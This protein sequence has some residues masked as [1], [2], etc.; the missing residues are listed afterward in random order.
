MKTA[1]SKPKTIISKKLSNYLKNKILTNF[2]KDPTFILAISGGPDSVA[3]LH[4]LQEIN[5][6]TILTHVN[7]NLRG[8][9]SK[10]DQELVE[11]YAKKFQ[12][13][14]FIHNVQAKKLSGNLENNC[15]NIRYKFFEQIQTKIQKQFKSTNKPIIIIAHN[16]DDKIETFLLNITRGSRLSGLKS[17]QEIDYTRNIF[18]PL[19][20]ISKIELLDYLKENKIK[21]RLDKSNKDTKFIRNFIRHKIIPEFQ[22]INPTFTKTLNSTIQNLTI[23]IDA[24]NNI[25]QKWL[26]IN[27]QQN[28]FS[29]NLFLQQEKAIQYQI[30][31][32]LYFQFNQ[33]NLTTPRLIEII[34]LLQKRKSNLKKEFGPKNLLKINKGKNQKEYI[35]YIS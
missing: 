32:I 30:I 14:L 17:I 12:L 29:L 22:K 11:Y 1:I 26:K 35:V 9:D 28:Q 7:Y 16:L 15:R 6:Q 23:N 13:Q 25:S 20:E 3:L 8:K 34:N 2:K 24:I 4:L 18:R 19:L 10:K 21:Y 31:S 33:K 27:F 5:V